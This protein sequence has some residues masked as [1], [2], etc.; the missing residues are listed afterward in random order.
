MVRSQGLFRRR[1][2]DSQYAAAKFEGHG[3]MRMRKFLKILH[4]L[5]ACGLTG[6][7]VCYMLLLIVAPQETPAAYADLRQ[8]I[9][10]LST[11]VL[12]P[13]L[14]IAPMSGQL[15]MAAHHPFLD[16]GWV[17]A[18]ADYAATV[19]R[20]I[21]HGGAASDALDAALVQD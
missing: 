9:P 3:A 11:Y 19:S 1:R 4:T 10:A 21:A 6:G 17:W 15:S 13:S 5:S 16:K 8:S 18:K 12:L 7:L 2:I 14:A 20:Q